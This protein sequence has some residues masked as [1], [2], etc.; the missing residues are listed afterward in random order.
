MAWYHGGMARFWIVSC[1]SLLLGAGAETRRATPAVP[2]EP[3]GYVSV[4]VYGVGP[5]GGA[6]AVLLG[7]AGDEEPARLVPIMI[8]PAEALA[9]HRRLNG[10]KNP[11]PMT[12]DLLDRMVRDLGGRIEKVQVD[13]VRGTTFI[14]TVFVRSGDQLIEVDARPSDAIALA[15]GNGVPV[16]VSRKVIRGSGV[17]IDESGLQ[18]DPVIEL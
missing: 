5:V 7:E 11:R 2:A 10:H 16:F 14:G 12:H 17:R 15:V 6:H 4:K 9:I 18:E 13:E 3:S 1:A 8:G